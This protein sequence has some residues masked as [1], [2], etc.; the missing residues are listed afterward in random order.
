MDWKNELQNGTQ[1][2]LVAKKV[3]AA[4]E[5]LLE[6]DAFLLEHNVNE[7]SISHRLAIYLQEQFDELHVDCEYNRGGHEAKTLTS[8]AGQNGDDSTDG[9]RVYPDIIVHRRG[10]GD[11]ELVIE[12]KKTTSSQT[13]DKDRQKLR[14]YR[15]ELKYKNS[16]F[17]E[18]ICGN[19]RAGVESVEWNV[20]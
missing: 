4:V 1:N 9:S 17:I 5:K 19:G 10:S 11:N 16:L 18:F 15:H 7:R 14:A 12:I 6:Q 20:S 3:L 8:I 2:R 13:Y